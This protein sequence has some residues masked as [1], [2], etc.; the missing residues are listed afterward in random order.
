MFLNNELKVKII[1]NASLKDYC[2][3]KIGGNAKFVFIVENNYSL[4]TM[5]KYCQKHN[6]KFKV[7]GYG[8]NLLFNDDGFDG[9]IIVNRAN[10]LKFVG[11]SVWAD[12]GVSVSSLIQKC[13]EKRLSGIERL[14]GIPSTVGGAVVNSL[15]AY[16][17][18]FSDYV[19]YAKCYDPQKNKIITMRAKDCSFAYR[20]S[21]FKHKNLIITSVK[22]KLRRGNLNQIK[23]N[24]IE[25]ISKKN[26]T[27][28]TNFPSAGSVF[29]RGNIIPARVI[30]ELGL[31]GLRVGGAEISKKHAGYI[32]NVENASS[33]DVK[34]LISII[35]QRVL[36][37]YGENLE[38]EIEF[39]E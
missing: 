6:I 32:I 13:I 12:A 21:A 10:N 19:K 15:G 38:T 5:C 9:A 8:S 30:D 27:Q 25:S 2:T 3:F 11:S 4:I 28:P 7:I 26:K 24:M 16:N 17:T 35:K 31:K 37:C 39:V 20:T 29:K 36:E 33:E 1:R 14:A 22:L 18:S 23:Q 34:G